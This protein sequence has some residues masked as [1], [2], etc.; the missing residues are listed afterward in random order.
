MNSTFASLA[1]VYS[2]RDVLVSEN[3]KLQV[4]N[5]NLV[6]LLQNIVNCFPVTTHLNQDMPRHRHICLK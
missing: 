3:N 6:T 5:S 2:M 1:K 4:G